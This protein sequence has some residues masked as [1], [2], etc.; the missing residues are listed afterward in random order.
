MFFSPDSIK[1]EVKIIRADGT[2]EYLGTVG[3]VTDNNDNNNA[4]DQDQK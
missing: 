4:D 3:T 1:F 2:E